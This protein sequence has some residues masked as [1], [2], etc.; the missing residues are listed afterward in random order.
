MLLVAFYFVLPML[1]QPL[2]LQ[3]EY[4]D[5]VFAAPLEPRFSWKIIDNKRAA[6]Q[7]LFQIQIFS[8][9]GLVWDSEKVLSP[10]SWLQE[11][12]GKPLHPSTLYSW[13]VRV[14]MKGGCYEDDSSLVQVNR[15]G[16]N[17]VPT[18]LLP[19]GLL[20]PPFLHYLGWRE[21]AKCVQSFP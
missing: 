7:E 1:A 6:Q 3:V 15:S 2:G 9:E 17:G 4:M 11:Y 16:L 19:P 10:S 12:T 18:P 8:R 13:R 5:L 21:M 20:T 14:Q